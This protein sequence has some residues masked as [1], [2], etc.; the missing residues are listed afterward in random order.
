MTASTLYRHA[1][2]AATVSI[3]SLAAPSMAMSQQ[4]PADAIVGKWAADDGTSKLDMYNAG[5]EYRARLLYGNQLIEADGVTIK[6]DVKNPDPALRDRSLKNIVFATRLRYADGEW[7]GG[8]VYDAASAAPIAA[9]RRSRTASCSFAAIWHSRV[10]A[11]PGVPPNTV[12]VTADGGIVVHQAAEQF[13][14]R[15]PISL[16]HSSDAKRQRSSLG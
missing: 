7:T 16:A 6:K 3:A 11:D 4:L 8:S 15:P 9:R 1:I 13:V 14:T 5:D 12:I 10:G 2:V